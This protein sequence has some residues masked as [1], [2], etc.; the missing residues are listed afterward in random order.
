MDLRQLRYFVAVAEERNFTAAARRLRMSQ[1]SLSQQILL[2]ERRMGVTLLDR[3]ARPLRLTSAGSHFLDGGRKV[4]AAADKLVH[5]VRRRGTSEAGELRI[6]VVRHGLYELLTR[7]IARVRMVAP[8]ARLPVRQV[9]GSEQLAALRRSDIDVLLYRHAAPGSLDDLSRLP[10]FDDPLIAVLPA[11]HPLIVDGA[12][13][14]A[15]LAGSPLVLVRREAM[16]IAYDRT[17][18]ACRE[19]G[20][21]PDEIV[22]IE[23]PY[24]LALV[25]A[26]GN[27]IAL[28][29]DGMADRYPGIAYVP[30]TPYSGI[31]EIS[32]VWRDDVDNPLR[33][34]FLDALLAALD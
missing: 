2:L 34:V 11:G 5:E 12:V 7:T 33:T 22:E 4:L 20:F 30:V 32:A 13:E 1:P 17:L 26:D 25:V 21:E 29:G 9:A 3:T 8:D 28:S 10:L 6:G 14:L 19:A 15:A 16:P 18:Q 27:G 23:D 31:A 24:T